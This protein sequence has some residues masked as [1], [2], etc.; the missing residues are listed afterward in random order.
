MLPVV[1]RLILITNF[2]NLFNNSA[3]PT[4]PERTKNILVLIISLLFFPAIHEPVRGQEIK[5][6]RQAEDSLTVIL[7]ALNKAENDS[8]RYVINKNF[9]RTLSDALNLPASDNATFESVK[10]LIKIASDDG[11]FRI[12]HWNLPSSDGKKRYFGFIKLLHNNPPVVITLHDQ[13]DSIDSPSTAIL[14]PQHWPGAL[15]YTAITKSTISGKKYY[16]LLGWA[17]TNAT[18][19]QKVIEVLSFDDHDLPQFGLPVFPGYEGG[20]NTRIIFRYSASTSM[21]LKYLEQPVTTGRKWNPGKREFETQTSQ[22]FR[23]VYDR[24][25][26]LDPLLEGQYQYYVASGEFYD[27]FQFSD[28]C[29]RFIKEVETVKSH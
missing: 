20:S 29:W 23:I 28:G 3:I 10:T 8:T 14:D 1:G 12:F 11:K 21:M 24:L 4:M 26:P 13:S 6:V 16:T 5:N 7:Q 15:Y 17:G 25:I 19:T 2:V 9:S 22:V 27:A 18:V